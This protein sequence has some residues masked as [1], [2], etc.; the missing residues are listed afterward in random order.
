MEG[1][2][3]KDVTVGQTRDESRALGET[4]KAAETHAEAPISIEAEIE[5]AGPDEPV[6]KDTREG[7]CEE[8]RGLESAISAVSVPNM[9]DEREPQQTAERTHE[10]YVAE[11]E[12]AHHTALRSVGETLPEVPN[13]CDEGVLAAFDCPEELVMKDITDGPSIGDDKRQGLEKAKMLVPTVDTLAREPAEP[14]ASATRECWVSDAPGSAT[15][16]HAVEEDWARQ[17]VLEQTQNHIEKF[18]VPEQVTARS[19]P[20]PSTRLLAHGNGSASS[21][22]RGAT[23]E[24]VLQFV[25]SRAAMFRAVQNATCAAVGATCALFTVVELA[26]HFGP[27]PEPFT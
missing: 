23:K 4:A 1:H 25:P 26:W 12:K 15:T 18:A 8:S 7:L 3:P 27:S 6:A 16:Q 22:H 10:E 14:A 17:V 20:P 9:D 13:S 11:G 19:G 5:A 21:S 2:W 24:H